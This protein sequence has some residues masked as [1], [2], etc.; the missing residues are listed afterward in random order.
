MSTR[1]PSTLRVREAD[2]QE[3]KKM[4][5]TPA[6]NVGGNPAFCTFVLSRIAGEIASISRRDPPGP[7]HGER[8][9]RKLGKTD[10]VD[11]P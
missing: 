8:F 3:L 4:P 5:E 7:V 10:Y 1:T 2:A 6:M 9:S 11:V